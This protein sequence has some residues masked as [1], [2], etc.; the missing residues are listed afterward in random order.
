MN[1]E[2]G[3]GLEPEEGYKR[4]GDTNDSGSEGDRCLSYNT[5]V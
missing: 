5:K 1:F 4:R 2:G 3:N